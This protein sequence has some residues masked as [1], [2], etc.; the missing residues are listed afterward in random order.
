MKRN[1]KEQQ[2]TTETTETKP[3]LKKPIKYLRELSVVIIGV[4]VTF[5]GSD[6][7]S[8]Q[9]SK[10][11]LKRYLEAVKI[12]LHDN[13]EIIREKAEFYRYTGEFAH[14]LT[15]DLPENLSTDSL[16][17][18]ME[19]GDFGVFSHIFTLTYKTSAFEMLKS[20]GTMHLISEN[21]LFQN[22]MD[23]YAGMEYIKQ[24]SDN[25]MARKLD[26]IYGSIM[27]HQTYS[28]DLLDPAFREE[29]F[30]FAIYIQLDVIFEECVAQI[31]ETLSLL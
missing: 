9:K 27:K 25:Y 1:D 28:V 30:F 18:L 5:I 29:Y 20:S 24:E 7:I 16:E 13:L 31:E 21:A 14:Y 8:N 2:T 15:S 19:Q 3:Q 6:W 11:D 4:A 12:E 17:Y 26:I 10:N 22:I 23:C